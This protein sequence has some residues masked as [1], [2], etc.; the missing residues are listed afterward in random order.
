MI[1]GIAMLR[2]Q[3]VRVERFRHNDA[4]HLEHFVE[5]LEADHD[6]VWVALRASTR[7]RE[8]SCPWR[9]FLSSRPATPRSGSS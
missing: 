1:D 4:A 3:G 5:K 9:S 7:C 6:V 2:S 8:T